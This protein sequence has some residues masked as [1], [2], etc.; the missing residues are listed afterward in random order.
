VNCFSDFP[1]PSTPA[2]KR[3]ALLRWRSPLITSR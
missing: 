3:E 2:E 1:L